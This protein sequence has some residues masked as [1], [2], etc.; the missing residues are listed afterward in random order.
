MSQHI[1]KAPSY[2]KD[3]YHCNYD[4]SFISVMVENHLDSNRVIVEVF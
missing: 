3:I 4:P 2:E 1:W